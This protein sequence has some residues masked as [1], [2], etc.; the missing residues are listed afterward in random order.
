MHLHKSNSKTTPHPPGSPVIE[1]RY[2]TVGPGKARM[3]FMEPCCCG[4]G[5]W[6][7]VGCGVVWCGVVWCG[8]VGWGG[9]GWVGVG[10]G[11]VGGG[12]VGWGGVGWGGVGGI[13]TQ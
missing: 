10:W 9:V 3:W 6:G 11:G 1:V 8:G 2:S 13:Y 12:G 5:A 4:A 7:G